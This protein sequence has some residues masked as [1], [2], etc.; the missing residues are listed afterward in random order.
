MWIVNVER[1]YVLNT[2]LFKKENFLENNHFT[3]YH[4]SYLIWIYRDIN[5]Q[6]RS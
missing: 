3:D 2:S 5:D 6:S 4:Q 1:R